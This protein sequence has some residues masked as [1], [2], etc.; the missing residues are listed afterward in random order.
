MS[1]SW[2]V[3]AF[4]ATLVVMVMIHESGHYST[5]RLFGMKVE[6]FFFGFGP[7]LVSWR[8]GETEYGVKAIPAGGYVKIA[9]MNELALVHDAAVAEKHGRTIDPAVDDGRYF[10]DKPAWQRAIV[11]AA[12]S[13]THFIMA[14]VILTVMFAA[15]G[16]IG[17]ATT[18]LDSVTASGQGRTGTLGP[19][20]KAGLKG[21]DTIVQA[22]GAKITNWNQ[23]VAVISGHAEQ[24]VALV[25]NRAGTLVNLTVTPETVPAATTKDPSATKGFIGVSPRVQ[26][27]R[28]SIPQAF[29][30][31]TKETGSL[32]VA[33]L[34]SIG[35]L[36]SPSGI[37]SIFNRFDQTTQKATGQAKA[38][39]QSN[40]SSAQAVGLVGGARLASQAVESGQGQPLLELLAAFIVFLGVL[41]LM[42]LPPLD[43]GHLLVLAIEKIRGRPVDARKVIPVA[44]FVLSVMIVL[45]LAILYLDLVHPVA[46]P[47]G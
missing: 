37:H 14:I 21:G 24:P 4:I 10:K 6:E 45:S 23:I 11:L 17:N 43:G 3:L 40:D 27:F 38:Q 25:V 16:T 13:A 30:S 22:D 39:Q 42:P 28:Q 29:W 19:A 18:T 9:G 12:G 1:G 46:N 26:E 8:R 15:L 33:S 36:F 7:K 44:A 20:A 2:G 32:I 5:A 41:N 34:Q 31:G 35:A 47:F